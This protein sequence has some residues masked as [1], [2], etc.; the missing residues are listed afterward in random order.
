MPAQSFVQDVEDM[1]IHDSSTD[2][3]R[4]APKIGLPED[5]KMPAWLKA[6]NKVSMLLK[7]LL[8]HH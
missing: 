6:Y 2:R 4:V 5:V 7:E 1:G 3:A 8:T